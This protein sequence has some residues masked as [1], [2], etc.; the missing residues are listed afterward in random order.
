MQP[1]QAEG[2][3]AFMESSIVMDTIGMGFPCERNIGEN[4]VGFY[5]GDVNTA[6]AQYLSPSP[7]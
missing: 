3:A 2:Q 1:R 7:A 4:T 6:A 5:D